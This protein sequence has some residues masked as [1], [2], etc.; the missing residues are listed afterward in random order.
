MTF[1]TCDRCLL[2]EMLGA[3]IEEAREAALEHSA[4]EVRA[5]LAVEREHGE[6]G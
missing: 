3:A 5:E 4:D 6:G 1:C 2:V